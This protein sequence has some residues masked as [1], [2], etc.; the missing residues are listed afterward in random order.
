MTF[1][2][3]SNLATVDSDLAALGLFVFIIYDIFLK[4]RTEVQ[5]STQRGSMYSVSDQDAIISLNLHNT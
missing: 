3:I 2:Y 5:I 1:L 4:Q